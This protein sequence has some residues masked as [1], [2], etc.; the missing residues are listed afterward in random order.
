M[1]SRHASNIGCNI[2]D[3]LCVLAEDYT[4]QVYLKNIAKYREYG[5][6]FLEFSHVTALDEESAVM[7]RDFCSNTGMT[8]WSLHSENLNDPD[9]LTEYL[10]A[11]GHCAKIAAALGANVMVC[12]IPNIEPRAKLLE[13]DIEIISNVAELTREYGVKLAVEVCINDFEHV[14][15]IVDAVK[16]A[17]VGMNI[18]TGHCFCLNDCDVAKLIRIA[19]KRILTLHLHDNFGSNDDHQMP[20]LGRIDW[21]STLRALKEVAYGG[22]L[23]MEMTGPAV[24]AHRSVEELRDFDL[25]KE[26]VCGKA[27]LEY[28]WN[29]ST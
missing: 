8:P 5:I 11:E 1:P 14:I 28:V 4:L 25:E 19:G 23:M 9:G 6:R 24:K 2:V 10:E 7:I 12:H 17:D 3:P 20:G 26:I 15:R 27:Y 21:K 22:P 29:T 13:R 16:R 18:D